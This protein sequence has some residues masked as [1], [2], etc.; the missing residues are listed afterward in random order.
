VELG[1]DAPYWLPMGKRW[2]GLPENT[3]QAALR[4][5]V[6]AYR[7]IVLEARDELERS[8]GVTLVHLMWLEVCGQIQL[9]VIT[10]DPQS[11]EAVLSDPE[12]LIDRHLR[13]T[14]IKCQ[15]AELLMKLRIVTALPRD[16]A[17]PLPALPPPPPLEIICSH[18]SP[19][20]HSSHS[21][22]APNPPE[23]SEIGNFENC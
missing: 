16:S 9:G 11:L 17:S 2:Q 6:P 18:A 12:Q 19:V 21:T 20:S 10:A 13:L 15:T 4:L 23:E 7:R 8:V 5:I 22:L 3:R 1:P 14:T